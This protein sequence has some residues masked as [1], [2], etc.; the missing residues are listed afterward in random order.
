M[1]AVIADDPSGAAELAKVA[2]LE[3]SSN[4]FRLPRSSRGKEVTDVRY[5]RVKR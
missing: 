4:A 3:E 5:D 2:M 1:I